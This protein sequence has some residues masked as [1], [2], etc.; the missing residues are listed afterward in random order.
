MDKQSNNTVAEQQKHNISHLSHPNL[1][2]VNDKNLHI[3][4]Q[5]RDRLKDSCRKLTASIQAMH[6]LASLCASITDA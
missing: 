2:H 3:L 1:S 5:E 6:I 4:L